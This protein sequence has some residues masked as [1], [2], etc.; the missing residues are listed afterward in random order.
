M[1]SSRI[2]TKLVFDTSDVGSF[3]STKS[4]NVTIGTSHAMRWSL[5]G[6]VPF[7][8]KSKQGEWAWSKGP[9]SWDVDNSKSYVAWGVEAAYPFSKFAPNID[10]EISILLCYDKIKDKLL[11]VAGGEHNGFPAYE[12]T[13]DGKVVHGYKPVDK[14]PTLW[15]L[16]FQT[17]SWGT[18]VGYH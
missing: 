1:G 14:G 7:S 4:P 8:L 16:A 18:Y 3:G 13:I 2:S 11:V 5:N 10:L 12:M 9:I 17:K 15:N 6:Y